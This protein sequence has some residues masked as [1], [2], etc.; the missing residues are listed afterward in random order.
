MKKISAQFCCRHFNHQRPDVT[1]HARMVELVDTRDLKSLTH[2]VC[3]FESDSGYQESTTSRIRSMANPGCF[4]HPEYAPAGS[5]PPGQIQ[6]RIRPSRAVQV[7][8]PRHREALTLIKGQR[9]RILCIDFQA[10]R[11]VQVPGVP[12]QGLAHAAS[13]IFRFHEKHFHM[14]SVTAQEAHRTAFPFRPCV[15]STLRRHSSARAGK[16]SPL[17][18]RTG[19]GGLPEAA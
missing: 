3:R 4:T 17:A 10:E 18:R 16:S 8:P 6:Q 14:R 15:A 19:Q 2:S 13:E 1:H 7:G 9:P 11:A 12:Q 5:S